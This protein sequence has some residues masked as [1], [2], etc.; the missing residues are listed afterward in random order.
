MNPFVFIVGCPRSGTTLL[1][2]ILNAHPEIA[3][4][5][6]SHW[7]PR[8]YDKPWAL[9]PEGWV[10]TKLISRLLTHRKFARLHLD[11]NKILPLLRNG[12]RLTY[13]GLVT[14]IFDCYG[15][16]EGKPLVGD[17][18]P[19]YVR[20]IDRLHALWPRARF[21]HVIR[22]G[23]DVAVS[24][25]DWPKV[26]PKPG[27][28]ATWKDDPIATAAW[29]WEFNVRCGQEVGKSLDSRLYYEVRY[30]SLVAHPEAEMA[31][32]F[33]FLGV[34]YD[35]AV[36]RFHEDRTRTDPGLEQKHAGRPVTRGLRDWETQMPTGAVE[37]FEAVAGKLLEELGYPGT[38]ERPCLAALE[39]AA[40]I[41]GLL[42]QDPRPYD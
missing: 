39:R 12:Q 41:R 30:E 20:R 19:D 15:E 27:N 1:Q 33:A 8:L 26:R 2:R 35:A 11:R 17:K 40:R 18:T 23:R 4:T 10:T 21:V 28:F 22:D 25:L 24:M 42:A 16:S 38:V 37:Q 13:S 34:P 36:L 7:I 3:I 14:T 29:W 6:E 5:P 9:T 32:L 31:A